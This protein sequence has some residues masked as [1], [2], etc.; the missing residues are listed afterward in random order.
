MNSGK[1]VYVEGGDVGFANSTTDIW[2]YLGAAYLADG[3]AS[4]NVQTL[5]G[6]AGTFAQGWNGTYPYLQPPDYWVDVFGAGTGQIVLRD[7]AANGRLVSYAGTHHRAVVSA[8][9]QCA[10]ADQSDS[11]LFEAIADYLLL[12][13][14]IGDRPAGIAPARLAVSPNPARRSGTLRLSLPPGSDRVTLHDAA[15]RLVGRYAT[16]G[17]SLTVPL[18]D[19]PPGAYF[20]RAGSLPAVPFRVVE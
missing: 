7:Q 5:A 4:G 13:T 1:P 8:V 6:V 19:L 15:G 12:G 9:A 18:G 20:A 16:D 2:P 17:V 14:A 3:N 10:I 11:E